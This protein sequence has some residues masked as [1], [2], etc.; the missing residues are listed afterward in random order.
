M[1]N[2]VHL[3]QLQAADDRA[4]RSSEI[5]ARQISVMARL[6]DD[7]MDVSRINHGNIELRREPVELSQVL[8]LAIE[9]TRP[10]FNEHGHALSLTMPE[11][12]ILLDA[13]VTRL[14]QV[15]I[16]LLTN[17]CKYTDRGGH[18]SLDVEVDKTEVRVRVTDDGIGIPP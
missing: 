11:Q 13:D 17:A 3:L 16:N 18:V 15:F 9:S 7:L 6:I 8:E 10:K 12:P 2:A 4:K 5:I 14:S 1:R